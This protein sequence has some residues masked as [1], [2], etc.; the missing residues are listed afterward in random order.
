MKRLDSGNTTTGFVHLLPHH[1]AMLALASAC[2]LLSAASDAV[3]LVLAGQGG[4][5]NS[6]YL[7]RVAAE[8]RQLL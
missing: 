5:A 6:D 7:A 1:V 3:A 8:R 2:T 4:Q